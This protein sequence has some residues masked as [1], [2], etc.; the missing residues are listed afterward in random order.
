MRTPTTLAV[1]LLLFFTSCSVSTT[2]LNDIVSGIKSGQAIIQYQDGKYSEAMTTRQ[3]FEKLKSNEKMY[4]SS[5]RVELTEPLEISGLEN[6][7]IIGNKTSF[8]AKI[9]MPV[10]TFKKTKNTSLYDLFV[11]HEIGEWCAQNCVE[12]YNA[13]DIDVKKCIFDGSGYFGLALTNVNSALIEDNQF[14]NCEYGLAAWK[15]TNL[16]VKNNAF[17]KNRADDIMVNDEEQFSNDFRK[18]NTFKE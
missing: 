7:E 3:A 11:V 18:E 16:T 12:F 10:I 1:I 13:S 17:N 6:I 5:G 2:S 4:L 14:F 15:S 8:V 9:D